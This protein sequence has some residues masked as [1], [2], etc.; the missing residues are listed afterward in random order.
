MRL[1]VIWRIGIELLLLALSSCAREE[2]G[3]AFRG[4]GQARALVL[5]LCAR[6]QEL[7]SLPLGEHTKRL[8]CHSLFECSSSY[9]R[10]ALPLSP[11]F[12]A[13]AIT[14]PTICVPSDRESYSSSSAQPG[15]LV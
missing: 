15:R 3:A 2:G 6:A 12:A 13:A 11:F 8:P 10:Y 5:S 9:A 4:L 14:A 7:L 1:I